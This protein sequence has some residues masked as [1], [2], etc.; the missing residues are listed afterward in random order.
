MIGKSTYSFSLHFSY[1]PVIPSVF[2]H[3]S[4]HARSRGTAP[5][6]KSENSTPYGCNMVTRF[7]VSRRNTSYV[8]FSSVRFP[9]PLPITYNRDL[10]RRVRPTTI[11][12]SHIYFFRPYS[13]HALIYSMLI[14]LNTG[15]A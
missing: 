9:V 2:M 1:S 4:T 13:V 5:F 8:F 14:P 15:L 7:S 12:C 6:G 10:N 11:L 3:F